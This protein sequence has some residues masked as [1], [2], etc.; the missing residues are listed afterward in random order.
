MQKIILIIACIC[1]SLLWSGAHAEESKK[2]SYCGGILKFYI[3]AYFDQQS[4]YKQSKPYTCKNGLNLK[5]KAGNKSSYIHFS[6]AYLGENEAKDEDY[7]VQFKAD[8]P[9]RLHY[10]I[11]HKTPNGIAT[12][13]TFYWLNSEGALKKIEKTLFFGKEKSKTGAPTYTATTTYEA[14]PN[15]PNDIL[16]MNAL[17][18]LFLSAEIDW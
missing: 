12:I 18:Q 1:L 6:N 5:N 13:L 8:Y 2:F 7:L 14:N 9:Q 3:P 11:S 10:I 17:E 4:L 15:D 16:F